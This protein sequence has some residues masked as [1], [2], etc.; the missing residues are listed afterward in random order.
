VFEE[1]GV[2]GHIHVAVA[3]D[4]RDRCFH[5]RSRVF[6]DPD[7]REQARALAFERGLVLDQKHPLGYRDSQ[8]A[9]CFEMRCPNNSL[10]VLWKDAP[11]WRALFPRF[12]RASEVRG[13]TL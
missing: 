1:L 2:R 11:G 4:D 5:E 7:A 10:P 13:P 3:L 9:V 12:A 8:T 6:P